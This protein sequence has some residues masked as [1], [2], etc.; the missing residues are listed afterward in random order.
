MCDLEIWWRVI[1]E[2][3][4]WFSVDGARV[5]RIR[6]YWYPSASVILVYPAFDSSIICFCVVGVPSCTAVVVYSSG[7]SRLMFLR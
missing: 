3:H 6:K 7:S 5:L 4:C 1:C 2:N